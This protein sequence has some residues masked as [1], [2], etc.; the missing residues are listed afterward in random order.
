M[1]YHKEKE[2][3]IPENIQLFRICL[4]Q[5]VKDQIRKLKNS[6]GFGCFIPPAGT[7]INMEF[8]ICVSIM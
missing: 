5:D 6:S 2:K 3:Y 8:I 4:T 1:Q 7:I